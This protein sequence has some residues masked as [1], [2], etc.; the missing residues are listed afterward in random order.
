MARPKKVVEEVQETTVSEEIQET[1]VQVEQP[2]E[3][4]KQP[5]VVKPVQL[6]KFDKF[7][8]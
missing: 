3:V 7:K 4:A 5:E 6:R 8:K 1:K 2:K